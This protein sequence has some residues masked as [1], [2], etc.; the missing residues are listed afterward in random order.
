MP[1]VRS[2][3]SG[4]TQMTA[5]SPS[6]S[7]S[8]IVKTVPDPPINSIDSTDGGEPVM[9]VA[10]KALMGQQGQ[11]YAL[12]TAGTFVTMLLPLVV[13]VSLQ[14]YFIRGMTSGAVKG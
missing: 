3:S 8:P 7:S 9:T 12:L 2:T 11:G 6:P 14:R 1:S 10:L 4:S 13:F 5:A